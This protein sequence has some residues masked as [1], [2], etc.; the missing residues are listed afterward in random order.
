MKKILDKTVKDDVGLKLMGILK[1]LDLEID[2]GSV[3]MQIRE[4]KPTLIIVENTVK[5]D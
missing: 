4:G 3:K 2:Y 5:L 1:Q